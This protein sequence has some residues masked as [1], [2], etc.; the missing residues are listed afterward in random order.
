MQTFYL[1]D[2]IITYP[3]SYVQ[4]EYIMVISHGS[5]GADAHA[6]QLYGLCDGHL[7]I[8]SGHE[9]ERAH[10]THGDR[11]PVCIVKL[12]DIAENRVRW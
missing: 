2:D 12:L 6:V 8:R 11:H 10:R 4:E 5:K 9:G 7:L 3:A 1:D